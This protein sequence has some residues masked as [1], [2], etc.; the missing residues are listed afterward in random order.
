M[1]YSASRTGRPRLAATQRIRVIL[2][3][4]ALLLAAGARADSITQ[5]RHTDAVPLSP[6]PGSEARHVVHQT[7]RDGEEPGS[8]SLLCDADGKADGVCT[9]G[10]EREKQVRVPVGQ[11]SDVTSS[12]TRYILSCQP[13]R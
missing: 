12:G 5:R 2:T 11:R 3:C 6:P 9:F 13:S 4:S 10:S 7:C 1:S 8:H